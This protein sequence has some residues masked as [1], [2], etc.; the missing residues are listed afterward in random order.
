[1]GNWTKWWAEQSLFSKIFPAVFFLLYWAALY[2][3]GSLHAD[4]VQ[5]GLIALA[6]AYGGRTPRAI[7]VFLLPLLMTVIIYDS[8]R[9]YADY[10]RGPIHV[11]EPYLFDKRFFGIRTADGV[12]TPNEYWQKHL[13]PALDLITGFAYLAF[14]AIFVFTISYF[15]FFC[16]PA[17][18][19][20]APAAAW[21]F[22][23]TNML[24]YTTY[25]WY[26]AAP[27]WYVAMYG[28]GPARMD[29]P[30]NPAGTARF[31]QMLGTHFFTSFYGRAADVFGAI[32][33]LHVSYPLIAAYFA[34]R[35]KR[36][37]TF[38][39]LFY[40]LMCFSAVYLNHHYVL[41]VLWG[42]TYA[43]VICAL[44][45]YYY[46]RAQLSSPRSI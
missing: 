27:P 2:A 3:L 29:T 38:T 33:S 11:S 16:G 37:R 22:F 10:L 34:F 13:Y 21:S 9:F 24:G 41:D 6:L 42:S 17:I 8:M 14:V 39:T 26:A 1:M 43:L 30:A 35:F 31:D 46:S 12:L 20:R 25:Y 44:L 45:D 5:V 18:G 15:R 19:R 23:W 40:L 36:V 7:L 32:P 28:L 4:H